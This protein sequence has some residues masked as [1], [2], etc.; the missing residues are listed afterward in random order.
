MASTINADTS[1]GVVVT[2]D[3][4]GEIELQSAGVT[5]A[6]VT[7]SG[8]QNASG[9]AIT[10][11]AGRNLIINGNMQIAQRA[12]SVTGI[13]TAGYRTVDRY[14]VALNSAG[15]WSMSQNTDVPTGQ[16]FTSSFKIDCTTAN[17]SLS[18]A[19]YGLAIQPIEAFNC[20]QLAYGAAGAKTITMSFWV[21][22]NK[23]GTYIFDLRNLDADKLISQAYTISSANTWEKKTLTFVGDTAGAINNDNGTGLQCAFWLAAGSN[24]SSGTLQTSWGTHSPA[25]RAVGQVN[26]ADSTSNYFNITGVQ[27]EVGTVATPFEHLQYGQQLQLCQRYLPA[28]SGISNW[29]GYGAIVNSSALYS[30]V[31][32]KVP[33]RVAPTGLVISSA[34]HFTCGDFVATSNIVSA[35]SISSAGTDSALLG[36]TSSVANLTTLRPATFY[37]SSASALLYF[38]GCEL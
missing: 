7:S 6:K 18:S 38:T 10:A 35:I 27:L 1:N 30:T 16:G 14:N 24:Y 28:F 22:S 17:A 20:Q 3:T 21:K 19:S 34:S 11:Q 13:T 23:T 26:L 32:Y 31:T 8:L 5:K 36:V 4:S 37:P 33:T 25:N 9:V 29:F 2:S 12:T 15:T